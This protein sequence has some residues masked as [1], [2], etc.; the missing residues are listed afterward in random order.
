[1]AEKGNRT[2]ALVALL[3]KKEQM[4]FSAIMSSSKRSSLSLLFNGICAEL[5][6]S[7][8]GPEK[9]L[10]FHLTF[11]EPY[12]KDKDYL[13]RNEFRLLSIE[14]LNYLALE[15]TKKNFRDNS[16]EEKHLYLQALVA[17]KAYELF[18]KEWGKV[19]SE[20]E[21]QLELSIAL[22]IQKMAIDH[23]VQHKQATVEN[24]TRLIELLSSY[25]ETLKRH[26]L[27]QHLFGKH[28]QAF[29]ERTLQALGS[30]TEISPLKS[31][32]IDPTNSQW[33]D[34][35][36]DHFVALTQS[37]QHSG[38]EKIELLKC[39][40]DFTSKIDAKKFDQ[41]ASL[42]SI[43]AGIALE[44]F[45]LREFEKSLPFHRNALGFGKKLEGSKLI[46]FVFN[47][48]STLIRLSLHKQAITLI[49]DYENVWQKLP[50]MRDRF[51][52]LKAMC[53]VFDYNP[54]AAEGC[55][56]EDRKT[57]G[58]DHYY[59]YRFIQIIV[60]YQKGK[61][62]LAI[63]EAENFEHTVRYND[64]DEDYL[65]LIQSMK[66]FL[67]L[68]SEQDSIATEAFSDKAKKLILSLSEA[69]ESAFADR[70]LLY[71]WLIRELA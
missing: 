59:Y 13:L 66:K 70:A 12:S 20:A 2:I 19:V 52:C 50:R 41:R 30:N 32:V 58:I 16:L 10:L 55:I 7:A 9:E 45:L 39:A 6:T 23:L 26:F 65:R 21:K 25:D 34:A 49:S 1:M 22:S 5:K 27:H 42:A 8:K 64:K 37:Y 48:L 54:K 24:Y 28:K 40:A 38:N 57:G 67:V 11:D 53:H 60:L 71:N 3:T 43:N 44:Y 14:L 69:S 51:L 4:A 61:S 63:T 18:D 17:R 62:E 46:S 68:K 47:Y 29:T 15:Q 31:I 35:Y 36:A 56:P 33:E